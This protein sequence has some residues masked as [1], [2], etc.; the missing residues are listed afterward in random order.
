MLGWSSNKKWVW[1]CERGHNWSAAV[2]HRT[3]G[4]VCPQCSKS[5]TSRVEQA[6]FRVM[7]T[8]LTD[9]VSGERIQ[10]EWSSKQTTAAIDVSGTYGGLA[11]SIEYDGEYWHHGAKRRTGDD[12]KTR[13]LLAAGYSVVRV[14]ETGL[15]ALDIDDPGLLQLDFVYRPGTDAQIEASLAPTVTAIMSWLEDQTAL[16]AAA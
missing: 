5:E 1:T 10:L 12:S 8:R 9:P 13:A 6:L 4:Q 11:V 7:S 16:A 3:A 14:R 2:Y 15:T